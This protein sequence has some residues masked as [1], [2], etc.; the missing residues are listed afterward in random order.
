MGRQQTL[1]LS[2]FL[3]VWRT[4]AA[5]LDGGHPISGPRVPIQSTV[6]GRGPLFPQG[7][8]KKKPSFALGRGV[9]S[10]GRKS[11]TTLDNFFIRQLG[12]H[13]IDKYHEDCF[14]G[15]EKCCE[16]KMR[17]LYVKTAGL[18]PSWQRSLCAHNRPPT[19]IDCSSQRSCASRPS[20]GTILRLAH[21][22]GMSAGQIMTMVEDRLSEKKR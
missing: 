6:W 7:R 10:I 21:A 11:K 22:L 18:L 20:L 1:A 17:C 13:Q 8:T 19:A 2:I 16:A 5:A 14:A 3:I 9:Q 15:S 4:S 12:I